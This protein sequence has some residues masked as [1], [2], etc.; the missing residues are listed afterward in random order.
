ME[1]EPCLLDMQLAT[2][3]H[4]TFVA[5]DNISIKMRLSAQVG[6]RPVIRL[7][8]ISAASERRL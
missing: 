1:N 3:F 5:V 6:V 8:D 2:I 4:A 7:S